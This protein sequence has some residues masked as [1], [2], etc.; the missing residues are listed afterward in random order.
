M[1]RGLEIVYFVQ[2][3]VFIF[4]LTLE[5]A[6][7]SFGNFA[8]SGENWERKKTFLFFFAAPEIKIGEKKVKKL[9][10]EIVSGN[11]NKGKKKNVFDL[12]M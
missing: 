9:H 10:N 7:S 2:Y 4:F 12:K 6:N 5:A 8:S 3:V 11:K 1:L